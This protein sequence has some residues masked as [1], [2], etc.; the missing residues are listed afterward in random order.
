MSTLRSTVARW[1]LL[2]AIGF[3]AGCPQQP[4]KDVSL[5]NAAPAA[6][7]PSAP[8]PSAPAQGERR[9]PRM[10]DPL[11]PRAMPMPVELDYSCNVDN[12]CAVKD[13]GNC[14]GAFPACVNKDS[15]TDPAAVKAECARQGQMSSCGFREVAQCDCRQGRC[16]PADKSPVGGWVD[17]APAGDHPVDGPADRSAPVR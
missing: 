1:C 6:A 17:D 12:D 8:A 4:A 9:A 5:R 7:A 15:P 13:V 10:S 16:V 14:C 3:V 11:P 2:L